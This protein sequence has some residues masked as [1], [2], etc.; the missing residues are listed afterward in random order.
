MLLK[1]LKKRSYKFQNTS[2]IDEEPLTH[3]YSLHLQTLMHVGSWMHKAQHSRCP[4]VQ[5]PVCTYR[6]DC[7]EPVTW[8]VS[9]MDKIGLQVFSKKINKRQPKYFIPTMGKTW[10]EEICTV[11]LESNE[12]FPNVL[13]ILFPMN[14]YLYSK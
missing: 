1:A 4:P 10:K 13:Q 6:C 7:G 11:L 9:L 5:R 12:I 14:T 2:R 8:H 3:H